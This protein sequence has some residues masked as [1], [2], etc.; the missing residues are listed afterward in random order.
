MDI[1]E[2]KRKA[3]AAASKRRAAAHEQLQAVAGAAREVCGPPVAESLRA[4]G[5]RARAYAC[6]NAVVKMP[7]LAM[8]ACAMTRAKKPDIG[9]GR[10]SGC[11]GRQR[12]ER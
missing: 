10:W 9:G 2:V 6:T 8:A 5:M 7:T 11:F 12:R 4:R 3:R 1:A